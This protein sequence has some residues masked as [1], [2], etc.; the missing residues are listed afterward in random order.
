MSRAPKR[1]I[2]IVR[3]DMMYIFITLHCQNSRDAA[4]KVYRYS[5]YIYLYILYT[6]ARPISVVVCVV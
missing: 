2:Y 6:L 3:C 1:K 4:P 5:L